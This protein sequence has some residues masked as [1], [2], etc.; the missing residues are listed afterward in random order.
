[1]WD[2]H[3]YCLPLP[4]PPRLT[5]CSLCVCVLEVQASL[6]QHH[7]TIKDKGK[8]LEKWQVSGTTSW[9]YMVRCPLSVLCVAE[10]G[11]GAARWHQRGDKASGK[12][13]Q[14]AKPSS[15]QGLCLVAFL[16]FVHVCSGT[17]NVFIKHF[18]N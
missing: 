9:S 12:T 16:N 17:S 8:L 15:Q 11:K 4:S 14:Q 1:M 3:L 10:R 2:I 5:K 13:G 18:V 7:K 6:D